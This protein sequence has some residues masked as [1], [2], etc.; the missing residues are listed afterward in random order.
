[1]RADDVAPVL[2]CSLCQLADLYFSKT[3]KRAGKIDKLTIG[4]C[5]PGLGVPFPISSTE[6][7]TEFVDKLKYPAAQALVRQF[8]A[9]LAI[10]SSG[11]SMLRRDRMGSMDTG[12]G[13][14]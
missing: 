11:G 5:R 8:S 1:M 13:R 12:A 6:L 14:R 10:A 9:S 4:L 7:S 3:Y 2:C